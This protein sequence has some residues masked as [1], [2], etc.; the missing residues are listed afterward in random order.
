MPFY[1][2]A[3]RH[4]NPVSARARSSTP[5]YQ[6][7]PGLSVQLLILSVQVSPFGALLEWI[8]AFDAAPRVWSVALKCIAPHPEPKEKQTK[9]Y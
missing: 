3:C 7:L 6:Q 5:H 4:V 2:L 1:G 9:S 8:G